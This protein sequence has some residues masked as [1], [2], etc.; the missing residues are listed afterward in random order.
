MGPAAPLVVL[1]AAMGGFG[2]FRRLT[3]RPD[4]SAPGEAAR[5]W[6]QLF[7]G[8][9]VDDSVVSLDRRTALVATGWGTGVICRGGSFARRLDR[10]I[11]ESDSGGLTIRFRDGTTPRI[12]VRLS[13]ADTALWQERIEAG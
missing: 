9:R 5:S 2:L 13:P 10:A 8:D 7:P 11:T 1:A 12:R 4:W 6:M 3:G